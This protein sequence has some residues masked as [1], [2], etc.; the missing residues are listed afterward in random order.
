MKLNES[1]SVS[2]AWSKQLSVFSQ[3]FKD[4]L[5]TLLSIK[6]GSKVKSVET[7]DP[8]LTTMVIRINN[9]RSEMSALISSYPALILI[10]N[11]F[12]DEVL[13]TIVDLINFL[14]EHKVKPQTVEINYV[15]MSSTEE[16]S[17]L[18]IIKKY[19]RV[20]QFSDFEPFSIRLTKR[21]QKTTELI[22]IEPVA[23]LDNTLYI[24]YV[25][26]CV[27]EIEPCVSKGE[28]MI[29]LLVETFV[30]L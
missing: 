14:D 27:D 19:V 30:K 24:N 11:Y 15:N 6:Y 1:L 29:K 28:K 26:K 3:S 18:D 20:E 8:N 17:T 10:F 22:T 25:I 12:E 13:N 23:N 16:S 2:F 7:K 21:E 9:E 5:A 4:Y